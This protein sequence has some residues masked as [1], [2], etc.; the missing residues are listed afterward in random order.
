[1]KL[2]MWQKAIDLYRLVWKLI[3]K[4][5][6]DLKIRSE[7]ADA[8]QSAPSNIAE[9]YCRRS[10]SESIQHL[11]V[12]LGSP[13]E[14]LTRIIALRATDQ[15]TEQEFGDIDVLHYEVENKLLA[16]V[17]RLGEKRDKGDWVDRVSEETWHQYS[18]TP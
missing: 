4:K 14:V 15:I 1:M 9:G 18:T 7:I 11:Y 8:A 2:E 5:G 16:L 3:S 17:D 12:S 10:V 6:I 13:G